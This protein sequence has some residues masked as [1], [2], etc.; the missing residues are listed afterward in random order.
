MN[1]EIKRQMRKRDRLFTSARKSNSSSAC[2]KFR[3]Y[4][5]KVARIV[6]QAHIDYV[7]NVVGAS[8][9]EKPETFWSYVK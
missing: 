8:L 4:R 9:Q 1:V 6:K 5:N 2:S 7:N 3:Q